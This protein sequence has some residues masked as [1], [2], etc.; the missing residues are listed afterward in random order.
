[1]EGHVCS[2]APPPRRS[3]VT[4]MDREESVPLDGAWNMHVEVPVALGRTAEGVRERAATGEAGSVGAATGEAGLAAAGLAVVA[5][6][7]V[8]ATEGAGWEPPHT[9]KRPPPWPPSPLFAGAP[10]R[11]RRARARGGV[12]AASRR[13]CA[14]FSLIA[15]LRGSPPC[16]R[17]C[18]RL[19]RQGAW[20]TAAWRLRSHRPSERRS[21]P[22]QRHGCC[23]A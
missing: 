5:I 14:P 22:T 8:G 13:R 11:A 19:P 10:L 17:Y 12:A 18:F 4:H 2:D 21:T 15:A 9:S 23:T 7:V 16:V 3:R 1:M 20:L 6:A